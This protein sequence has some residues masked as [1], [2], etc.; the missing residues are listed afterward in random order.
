[1]KFLEFESNV[2]LDFNLKVNMKE[3]LSTTRC[4]YYCSNCF[5]AFIDLKSQYKSHV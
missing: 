2:F 4:W 5:Q 3:N 1:M